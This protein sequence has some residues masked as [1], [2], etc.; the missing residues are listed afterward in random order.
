MMTDAPWYVTYLTLHDDLQI[1]FVRD[2]IADRYVKHHWK[3]V[4]HPN[5]TLQELLDA[6]QPRRLK[7]NRPSDLL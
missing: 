3:L 6:N 5:T 1:P 4:T 7:R 2:V